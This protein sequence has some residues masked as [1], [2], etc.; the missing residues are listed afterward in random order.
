MHPKI[1]FINWLKGVAILGV[2]LVHSP[3]KIIGLHQYV[4]ELVHFGAFGC[5]L[6]FLISGYLMVS[7][8]SKLL[9]SGISNPYWV[10]IKRRF[11]SIAPIYFL[12]IIFYQLFF[13]GMALLGI[14]PI[15]PIT[16]TPYSI[17]LNF[18]LLQ[19]VD[20]VNFNNV[21]PGGWFIGTIW[22]FYLI[23]PLL[24]K[25]YK[26]IEI[27]GGNVIIIFPTIIWG[28][29]FLAQ[30]IIRSQ[31]GDWSLSRPGTYL[32]Y[33]L[34]NQL[35]CMAI[36]M[37]LHKIKFS[38]LLMKYSMLIFLMSF[39]SVVILYYVFRLDYWFFIFIPLLLSISFV[40]LWAALKRIECNSSGKSY[41]LRIL[42][43]CGRYSYSAYYTNF[44]AC[45]IMPWLIQFLIAPNGFSS[46]YLFYG[47]I[48]IPIFLSTFIMVKPVDS[49]ISKFKII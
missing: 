1:S 8:W 43:F 34:L 47:I 5:Q 40:F 7:S 19:G 41:I 2:I 20:I 38:T 28:V 25:L 33:S 42:D 31:V 3:Q 49:I 15:F 13:R 35:P 39:S 36:G 17:A 37:T 16:H 9:R 32:Y 14:Q 6:F 18:L 46:P 4:L 29:S 27:H 10:F 21:V 12:F 11:L 30:Y 23:F 45:W 44:I 26:Q 24:Y 22:I 48:L